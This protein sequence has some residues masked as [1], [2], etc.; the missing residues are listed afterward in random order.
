MEWLVALGVLILLSIAAVILQ[1][2]RLPAGKFPYQ[3]NDT[4]FSKAERSFLGVLDAA[5][6][7]KYRVFGKVRVGDVVSVVNSGNKGDWQRAFNK[8]SAKHFDFVVCRATA[9]Q[10]VAVI[11]LDDRSHQRKKRRERDAFLVELCERISLPLLRFPAQHRYSVP[12]IQERLFQFADLGVEAR[13]EPVISE[14]ADLIGAPEAEHAEANTDEDL[15]IDEE[16]MCPKCSSPMVR[17]KSR[18]GEN[19]GREFWGCSTFPKCRG[20]IP[21][22]A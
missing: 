20:I 18:S 8:I 9:L 1:R 22:R 21:I 7:D 13:H 19:A 17:R 2:Q 12:E 14:A 6:G 3:K 15:L 10:I 5:I 4:L 16:L 11:E